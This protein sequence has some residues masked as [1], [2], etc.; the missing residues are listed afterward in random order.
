[1]LGLK[2]CSLRAE[3][4]AQESLPSKNGLGSIPAPHKIEHGD[5]FTPIILAS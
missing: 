4:V 2:N 3:D 5:I 1:M